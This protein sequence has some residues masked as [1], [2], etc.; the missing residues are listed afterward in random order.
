M[1]PT[2]LSAALLVVLSSPLLHAEVD[3][4]VVA[5]DVVRELADGRYDAAVARFAPSMKAKIGKP[6]VATVFDPLRESRGPAKSVTA[7]LRHDE[8]DGAVTFTVKCNWAR[9]KPSDARVVV[10]AD[11]SILGLRIADEVSLDDEA[12]RERYQT[13]ARLRPPFHGAWTAHNAARTG[14]NPHWAVR[15]QK[16]AVDWVMTGAGGQTFRTDGKTN[17]DYLAYGQEALA[18]ADGTVAVVVDGIPE[19][20]TPGQRDGYFVPGNHVVID[21]GGGEFAMFMN[22]VPGSIPVKPGS[23]VSAGQPV[24]HVGNSGNSSE[25]HLHFQLCDG[26]RLADCASLPCQFTDVNLDGKR[27][28]RAQPTEGSRL[29]E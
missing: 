2:R 9:G 20:P 18:P 15:S 17:A 14:D 23:K 21:L 11:G 10:A 6:Q 28:A 1:R 27:A 26:P 5:R 16:F 19:N 22:L 4:E 13:R 12:A 7:R 3:P 8:A 24:G 25:P 29:S